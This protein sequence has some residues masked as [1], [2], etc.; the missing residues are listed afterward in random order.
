[1]WIYIFVSIS[2]LLSIFSIFVI[3]RFG[4]TLGTIDENFIELNKRCDENEQL[5]MKAIKKEFIDKDGNLK[6]VYEIN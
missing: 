1:M 6:K 2:L 3:W 5:I 4:K